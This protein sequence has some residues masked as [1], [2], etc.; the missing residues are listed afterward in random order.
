MKFF[1]NLI[2]SFLTILFFSG[3]FSGEEDIY[4]RISKNIDLFTNVY[5]EIALN[6]V[7]DVDPEK[8]MRAGIDGMLKTLDPYTIFID[9]K[10][11]NDIELITNGKYGGIGITIGVRGDRVTVVEVFKDYSAE[12]QGI[13]VGDVLLEASGFKITPDN[14][15]DVSDYVKGEPGT[16]V[17]LKI[18][19]N[20]E[21]DTLIFNL[22]REEIVVENIAFADFIP[23]ESDNV[24]I[25]LTNFSRTA[26]DELKN[27]LISLSKKRA[28][29]S[30]VLDLRGNP[31][32]LLDVAVDVCEKFLEKNTLIVT[33]RGRDIT[34]EKQYYAVEEPIAGNVKLIVLINEGSA[35]A[36]EIVAGAIQDHDRGVI[37]GEKSFG[38]GLVQTITPLNYNASLKIT[39]AKYY[40]PSGRCIQKVDYSEGSEVLTRN[41][42]GIDAEFH[43]D[44]QRTVYASGGITPDTIVVQK[45]DSEYLQDLLAKGYIFRFADKFYY[46]NQNISIPDIS[47]DEL[48][49]SF[50]DYLKAENYVFTPDEVKKI[51]GLISDLKTDNTGQ[52]ILDELELVKSKLLQSKAQIPRKL[53]N[54]ILKNIKYELYSRIMDTEQR[55]REL[56]KD[57]LQFQS[58]IGLLNNSPAFERLLSN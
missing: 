28:I 57:D 17:Q 11:K 42:L 24:Y 22:I 58:A 15:D 16:S 48:Y 18:L 43:T 26:G 8:F 36:S 32:G 12:R 56:L 50:Q 45:Q 37:L 10:K 2:L 39:T 7:D 6:Y 51:E 52:Q 35:S 38:K 44:N 40:T 4:F 9:E 54:D 21:Q 31:G 41:T 19:R 33:T 30:V 25:K 5:K 3:F 55:T 29:R 14:L 47:E 49:N 46:S 27:A 23:E 53:K 1:K 34:T 13:K 20:S